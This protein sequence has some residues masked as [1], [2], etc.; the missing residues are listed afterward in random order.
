MASLS[1]AKP[2]AVPNDLDA[3]QQLAT[4]GVS[5]QFLIPENLGQVKRSFQ[6]KRQKTI[7]HIQDAHANEEAQYNIA[8]MIEYFAAEHGLQWVGVEGA[9]GELYTQLLSFFP[10]QEVRRSVSDYYLKQARMGGAEYAAIVTRPDLKLFGVEKDSLY[11]KNRK[12]YL[13]AIGAQ[14]QDEEVLAALGERLKGLSRFVFSDEMRALIKQ[15]T[16]FSEGGADLSGYVGLLVRMAKEQKMSLYEY[17]HMHSLLS[18]IDLE[19]EIDFDAADKEIDSLINDLKKTISRDRLSRFLTNTIQFRMKKIKRADYYGFLEGEIQEASA[20][21]GAVPLDEK[22][23]HVLNYLK[24]IRIYDSI[25]LE[26]FDE[27]GRLESAL[28]NKLFRTEEE[29]ELDRVLKIF[30]IYQ[31]LF[32]FTLTKQDAD[33]FFSY[34]SEF[35]SATFSHFLAPLLTKYHFSD[36]LPSDLEILDRDLKRIERFYSMAVKRDHVLVQNAVRK[37]DE[38]GSSISVLITGGFHTPGIEAYLREQDY[39]YLVIAPRI[40]K[41]MDHDKEESLYKNAMGL[42]PIPIQEKLLEAFR[43]PASGVLKDPRF[44][45]AVRPMSPRKAA[46]AG[47]LAGTDQKMNRFRAAFALNIGL[48]LIKA[49]AQA[50]QA[51]VASIP[52]ELPAED[53]QVLSLEL[54][55][56]SAVALPKQGVG[57]RYLFL[58]AED[59][60]H[61]WVLA[62]SGEDKSAIVAN[63]LGLPKAT[64]DQIYLGTKIVKVSLA[65]LDAVGMPGIREELS[66]R[67]AAYLAQRPVSAVVPS[68]SKTMRS[69]VRSGKKKTGL[70]ALGGPEFTR[71]DMLKTA[72]LGTTAVVLTA[73][74]VQAQEKPPLAADSGFIPQETVGD[75]K[76]QFYAPHQARVKN[77]KPLA[78]STVRQGDFP[79]G[80]FGRGPHAYRGAYR[81]GSV[82]ES[83]PIAPYATALT[84]QVI[85]QDGLK[86]LQAMGDA[87]KYPGAYTEAGFSSA[88]NLEQPDHPSVRMLADDKF[89]TI[90]ALANNALPVQGG[91]G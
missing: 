91:A 36:G 89:F 9:Q 3:L 15:R 61:S 57:G 83:G 79:D 26:I 37:M 43:P 88:V 29:V 48:S 50:G 70:G 19:S 28:K 30:E 55:R 63:E 53:Q 40:V 5:S 16:Q 87:D 69:E 45:L 32:D 39:S 66:E 59:Q 14:S 65:D 71:R 82:E 33:F 78:H 76:A 86:A 81:Q 62:V 24:Y 54:R 6:G 44:Q 7:I 22:Y 11:E 1:T 34:R 35:N 72:A 2:I 90:A 68:T 12:A 74:G 21:N 17:P 84:G 49:P 73:G 52:A 31:H 27:I 51:M 56:L 42:K 23:K 41:T 46:G 4:H 75:L 25:G 60:K 38:E 77:A 18:L 64:G 13:A 67:Q 8:R 80:I 10:D 47:F 58:P 85:P 20:Q